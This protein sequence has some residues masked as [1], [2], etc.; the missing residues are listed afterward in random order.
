MYVQSRMGEFGGND[1]S[2]FWNILR[3]SSASPITQE[4]T[5][6]TGSTQRTR[7]RISGLLTAEKYYRESWSSPGRNDVKDNV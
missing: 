5:E 3:R 1:G 2:S 6:V 4:Q 7:R